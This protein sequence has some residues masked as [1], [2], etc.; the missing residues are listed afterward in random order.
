MV[1]QFEVALFPSKIQRQANVVLLSSL[2][3]L[4]KEEETIAASPE[5][6]LYLSPY[7]CYLLFFFFF[8]TFL[9]DTISS[10]SFHCSPPYGYPVFFVL[11]SKVEP[12]SPSAKA[13]LIQNVAAYEEFYLH[14]TNLLNLE[15]LTNSY[16]GLLSSL[17]LLSPFSLKSP[18]S[19]FKKNRH[20]PV[21]VSLPNSLERVRNAS[22]IQWIHRAD[23]KAFQTSHFERH[24]PLRPLAHAT[25]SFAKS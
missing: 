22:A 15:V 11:N 19:F 16:K 6:Y 2:E 7:F 24:P 20:H 10:F 3:P 25:L 9:T 8:P 12:L 14:L 21:G 13:L 4:M 23:E 1:S 5:V 17:L 18:L